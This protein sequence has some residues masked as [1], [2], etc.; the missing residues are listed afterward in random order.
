MAIG[1]IG[2]ITTIIILNTTVQKCIQENKPVILSKQ[3]YQDLDGATKKQLGNHPELPDNSFLMRTANGQFLETGDLFQISEDQINE[4]RN[5]TLQPFGMQM[6]A[7][8]NVSLHLFTSKSG[9]T[10]KDPLWA[11]M[12]VY[13]DGEIAIEGKRT[14]FLG[15]SPE[16]TGIEAD[17][18]YISF[19]IG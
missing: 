13:E 14:E 9:N 5:H 2:I 19:Y 7:P 12:T 17:E 8:K 15:A 4:F 3:V 6:E 16:E 11:V 10:Y 1:E 18:I